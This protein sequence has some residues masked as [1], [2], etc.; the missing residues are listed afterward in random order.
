MSVLIVIF[1][2]LD[3]TLLDHDNYSFAHATPC[4]DLI[5][6]KKIPLIFTSSKTAIEIEDLCAQTNI[7]HPYIAENGGLLA[8]PKNYFSSKTY[9]ETKYVKKLISKSR[10]DINIALQNTNIN[11]KFKSLNDMTISEIMDVTGLDEKQAYY[12]NQREC[13]EPIIWQDSNDQLKE[14]SR[15]LDESDLQLLSGGR[16]HLVMG[17]HDKSTAMSL[18]LESYHMHFDKNT[19]SIA[20]G[21]SPNDFKMLKA[22]NYGI[23]IPNPSAPKQFLDNN[24]NLIYA[25]TAGPQGWNDTLIGLLKE[26]E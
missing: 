23:V 2:D 15:E 6:K 8:I 21:D 24:G 26:L 22:A 12:A 11:Y 19:L 10:K 1:T 25:T 18:L 9:S 16:F 20:L 14:F 7:Y 5:R 4:L 3:G 17:Q 13:T